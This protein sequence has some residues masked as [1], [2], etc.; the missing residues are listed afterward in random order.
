MLAQSRATLALLIL[1]P[2]LSL[3][4]GVNFLRG[5]PRELRD[6]ALLGTLGIAGSNFLYYFAIQKT[7]VATAIIL[8]YLAPV[9]VL[10]YMLARHRQRPTAPRILG[11]ALAV[12]GCFR[13]LF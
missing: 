13:W 4:R 11:V 9:F 8:Q 10:L 2:L 1:L 12:I 3:A 7:S 5:N 6:A